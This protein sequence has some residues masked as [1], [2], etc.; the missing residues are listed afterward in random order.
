MVTEEVF[1]S[2][3]AKGMTFSSI[4]KG[5]PSQEPMPFYTDEGIRKLGLP[6]LPGTVPPGV[7]SHT[8]TLNYKTDISMMEEILSP[9]QIL[10]EKHVA[11]RF[12]K[13]MGKHIQKRGKGISGD[14]ALNLHSWSESKSLKNPSDL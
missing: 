10:R 4:P 5:L 3:C 6:I 14:Q 8:V 11:L 7:V 2:K 12:A 13:S 9:R 1:E